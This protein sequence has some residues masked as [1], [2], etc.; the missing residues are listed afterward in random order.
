V[1]LGWTPH[2]MMGEMK[3]HY[4]DG[5]G[6]SGFGGGH[7]HTNVRAGYVAECPNVGKFISNLKFTLEMEGAMMDAV[8]KDGADPKEVAKDWLKAHPDAV[9]PWLERRHHLRRRRCRGSRAA[10]LG[11][12]PSTIAPGLSR[13]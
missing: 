7:G 13:E 10:A 4:L 2:P 11:G 9:K 5:M 1:F 3:I 8:L 12:G 6:D